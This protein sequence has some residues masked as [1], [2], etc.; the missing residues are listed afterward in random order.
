MEYN[1]IKK[2]FLVLREEQM[3]RVFKN[4]IIIII[5][6]IREFCPRTGP[7]LKVQEPRLQ[8]CRRQVFHRKLKIQGCKF[9]EEL[10]RCGSFPLLSAPP[11]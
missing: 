1:F 8:F 4:L 10:N 11:L 2:L 9:N 7:S 3:L 6:I 5:I